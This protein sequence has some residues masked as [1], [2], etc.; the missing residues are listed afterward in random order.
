MQIIFDPR[1]NRKCGAT[2]ERILYQEA[3]SIPEAVQELRM[4]DKD[5]LLKTLVEEDIIQY[6]KQILIDSN[7]L[8]TNHKRLISIN[9]I[10]RLDMRKWFYRMDKDREFRF[11]Q[12]GDALETIRSERVYHFTLI[13]GISEVYSGIEEELI[14]YRIIAN[15]NGIRR[16]DEVK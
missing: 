11:Y 14:R 1:N 5:L 3:T 12:K 9:E 10:M 13:I 16:I 4:K 8:L 7:E 2:K 6:Q 15:S